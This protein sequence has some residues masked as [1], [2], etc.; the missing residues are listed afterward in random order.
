MSQMISSHCTRLEQPA[1]GSHN[2]SKQLFL[3]VAVVACA[4]AGVAVAVAPG[5]SH[6]IDTSHNSKHF[7][8]GTCECQEQCHPVDTECWQCMVVCCWACWVLLLHVLFMGLHNTNCVQFKF[9]D[10]DCSTIDR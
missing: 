3:A 9:H 4:G 5:V 6:N 7:I 2:F 8:A 1:V 10:L